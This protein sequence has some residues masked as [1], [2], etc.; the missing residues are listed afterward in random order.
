MR[1]AFLQD[2]ERRGVRLEP[3]VVSSPRH[4]PDILQRH[5]VDLAYLAEQEREL[6]LVGQLHD[7]LVDRLALAGGRRPPRATT[8]PRTAP[9]L[10]A[11]A[12]SAPGLSGNST[13][14]RKV[15]MRHRVGPF[16]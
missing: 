13:R 4:R 7:E 15:A 2:H 9:I 11:T 5:A 8:S 12:P 6:L 14:S 10:L 1:R 3:A 16:T